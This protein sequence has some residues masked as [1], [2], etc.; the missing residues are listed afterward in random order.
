MPKDTNPYDTFAQVMC[1]LALSPSGE[2]HT[3]DL[4]GLAMIGE[5]RNA[6]EQWKTE[7]GAEDLAKGESIGIAKGQTLGERRTLHEVLETIYL[8]RFGTI[9]DDF[10]TRLYAIQA[11][12][13]LRMLIGVF[14]N[15]SQAELERVIA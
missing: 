5:Y 3:E 7:V 2:T 13:R 6:V 10:K 4:E 14:V 8:S 9:P 12:D 15:Q 1:T 11:V